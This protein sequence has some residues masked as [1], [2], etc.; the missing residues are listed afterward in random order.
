MAA[1]IALLLVGGVFMLGESIQTAF[2][3][4]G[5]CVVSPSDCGGGTGPGTGGGGSGGGGS[6]PTT[7]TGPAATTTST[8]TAATAP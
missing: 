5:D 6:G 3:N 7:S 8:A 1:I 4:G 2:E